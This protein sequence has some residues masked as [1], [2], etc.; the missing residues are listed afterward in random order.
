MCAARPTPCAL[1]DLPG[2]PWDS[3]RPSAMGQLRGKACRREATRGL[4]AAPPT[5]EQ[6]RQSASST[7][8]A[9]CGAS[10]VWLNGRSLSVHCRHDRARA[11]ALF[12]KGSP[13][14][15]PCDRSS[16][17]CCL[18]RCGAGANDKAC[19]KAPER[20]IARVLEAG[21][22][23]R[24]PRQ[25]TPVIPL[26]VHQG[27]GKEVLARRRKASLRSALTAQRPPTSRLGNRGCGVGYLTGS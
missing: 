13:H 18:C 2:G 5:P 11:L 26:K 1:H 23:K 19:A 22:R 10:R 25:G 6:T 14:A 12:T 21:Q 8:L 20:G 27:H 15:Y 16:C 9:A 7:V 3:V 4:G 17:Q 24:S